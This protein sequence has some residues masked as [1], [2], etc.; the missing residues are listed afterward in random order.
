MLYHKP[1]RISNLGYT[2]SNL[3]FQ[4]ECYKTNF[5]LNRWFYLI[6]SIAVFVY[7]PE[8]FAQN[9]LNDNWYRGTVV[10]AEGDSVSGDL[11]YD[12]QND[13]V[14][15]NT[16]DGVKAFSARQLWSFSFHDPD[17]MIERQFYAIPYAIESNYKVPIL[18]ELLTEGEVSLLARE[19][20]VTENVPQYGYGGYGA[21][22][23]T[24]TRLSRD[25]FFGFANGTVKRYDGSKKDFYYLLKD[26][27]NELKRFANENRLRYDD[28]RDLI[29]LLNY[30]NSL[31]K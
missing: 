25:Y 1:I 7:T 17:R 11:H 19:K 21:Y 31:K 10:L 3:E 22:S 23:Y 24:R 9:R 26:K 15:I 13:L 8:V 12:L 27:S 20:L 16:N 29:Q 14:Q 2:V 28:P 30:Y 6:L 18:F 5:L 4:R